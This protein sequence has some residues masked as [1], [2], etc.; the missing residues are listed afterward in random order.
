METT[1]KDY[2]MK[3]ILLMMISLFLSVNS[4]ADDTMTML[5]HK[6][7]KMVIPKKASSL[8]I[9]VGVNILTETNYEWRSNGVL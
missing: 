1:T 4:F 9:G 6:N 2:S 7:K 3:K 8:Q 5:L